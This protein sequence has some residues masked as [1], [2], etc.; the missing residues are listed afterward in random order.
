VASRI[1]RMLRAADHK[2]YGSVILTWIVWLEKSEQCWHTPSSTMP[3]KPGPD[4]GGEAMAAKPARPAPAQDVRTTSRRTVLA[5]AALI[6][7][8]AVIATMYIDGRRNQTPSP[9]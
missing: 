1:D 5:A 4:S 6:A 9:P 7:A 3:T 2:P 8:V